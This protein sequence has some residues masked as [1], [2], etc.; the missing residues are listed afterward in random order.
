MNQESISF[1][2]DHSIKPKVIGHNKFQIQLEELNDKFKNTE[3][4]LINSQKSN[5]TLQA[6]IVLLKNENYKLQDTNSSLNNELIIVNTELKTLK[7]KYIDLEES[8]KISVNDKDNVNKT[9]FLENL[10]L[11]NNLS[12]LLSENETINTKYSDIKLQYQTLLSNFI[13][14]SDENINLTNTLND[15]TTMCSL[16]KDTNLQLQ[17]ELDSINLEM[18]KLKKEILLQNTKLQEKDNIIGVLHFKYSKEFN[19]IDITDTEPTKINSLENEK[20]TTEINTEIPTD[21]T[22]EI[23]EPIK[24]IEKELKGIKISSNRGLKLSKR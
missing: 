22:T 17:T 18:D 12:S 20:F 6:E 19:V 2:R 24:S 3:E 8:M 7:Q 23:T 9:I 4:N 15:T 11:T 10:S 14:K 1:V 13:I 5:E 16:Y 21:I